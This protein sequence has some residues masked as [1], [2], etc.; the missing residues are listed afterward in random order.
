MGGE[1]AAILRYFC[2]KQRG[3][4]CTY[5]GFVSRTTQFGA[6]LDREQDVMYVTT[7]QWPTYILLEEER[8]GS[9]ETFQEEN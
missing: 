9:M 1:H 3:F 7:S 5:A 4:E 6:A 2:L 8:E